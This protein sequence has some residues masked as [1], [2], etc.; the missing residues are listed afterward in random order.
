[1]NWRGVRA[2]I[3]SDTPFYPGH[4]VA[5]QPRLVLVVKALRPPPLVE[6]AT[7]ALDNLWRGA[8]VCIPRLPGPRSICLSVD[9][10]QLGA[11]AA[12][13]SGFLQWL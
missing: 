13:F 11:V 4:E 10:D 5:G 6:V 9:L 8:R 7:Y 2:G 12:S 1:M 3:R